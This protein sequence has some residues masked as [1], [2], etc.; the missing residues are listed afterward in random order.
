MP[1][2]GSRHHFGRLAYVG[3]TALSARRRHPPESQSAP[4]PGPSNVDH[5]ILPP[6]GPGAR[7]VDAGRFAEQGEACT[8]RGN[9]GGRGLRP[10]LDMVSAFAPCFR[11]RRLSPTAVS[12]PS[13][14]PPGT[15]YPVTDHVS[16][17]GSKHTVHTMNAEVG[18]SRSHPESS[19]RDHREYSRHSTSPVNTSSTPARPSTTSCQTPA[20]SSSWGK[21][22]RRAWF[23]CFP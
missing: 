9:I 11:P 10:Y 17:P 1:G 20:L 12:R 19:P 18:M 22:T 6:N 8:L 7:L 14:C 4:S 21:T 15:P 13:C 3:S 16:P 5:F 2:L 23:R